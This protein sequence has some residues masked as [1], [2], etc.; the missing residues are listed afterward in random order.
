M[1]EQQNR[2]NPFERLVQDWQAAKAAKDVNAPFCT[3]M[4]LDATNGFPTGR[5]LGLREIQIRSEGGG[6]GALVVYTSQ[7]SPKWQ[8][9][10]TDSKYEIL[11]FWTQPH[12]LQYRL[13]GTDWSIAD[14]GELQ[15]QY[16]NKLHPA[17]L[18]DVYYST[19][20]GPSTVIDGGRAAF[21]NDMA[22]IA[23]RF[24][25]QNDVPFPSGAA[26]IVLKPVVSGRSFARTL[27]TRKDGPR[28]DSKDTGALTNHTL[29]LSSDAEDYRRSKV[30][31]ASEWMCWSCIA[32]YH[33]G[34]GLAIDNHLGP[35]RFEKGSCKPRKRATTL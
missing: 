15:E 3:L 10:E 6:G 12:M 11:L 28:M 26:G 22:Q 33:G 19:K 5:I 9:L 20:Q 34:R 31:L 8:Q 25:D 32:R 14:K 29:G 13:S 30:R 16:A 1:S 21:V 27:S 4:T 35:M 17:K 23:A 24:Q 18:L 2:K 7:L